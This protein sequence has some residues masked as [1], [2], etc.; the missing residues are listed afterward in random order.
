MYGKPTSSL[1]TLNTFGL[2]ISMSLYGLSLF[3]TL[4]NISALLQFST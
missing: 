3:V 2:W 4:N 1:P